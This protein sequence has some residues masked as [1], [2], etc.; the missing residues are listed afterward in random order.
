MTKISPTTAPE[1]ITIHFYISTCINLR[2]CRD[3]IEYL[4]LKSKKFSQLEETFGPS[5]L[6]NLRRATAVGMV[7]EN[8]RSQIIPKSLTS[9]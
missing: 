4:N 5:L 6:D 9:C 2:F 7:W 3:E 8:K 1:H